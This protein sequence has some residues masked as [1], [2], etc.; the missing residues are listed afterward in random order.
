M[1]LRGGVFLVPNL[2][3]VSFLNLEVAILLRK[4]E[5]SDKSWRLFFVLEQVE[6]PHVHLSYSKLDSFSK[7]SKILAAMVFDLFG[8]LVIDFRGMS[9]I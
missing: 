9:S 1:I 2:V 7:T 4:F 5:N 3:N 6:M 8:I